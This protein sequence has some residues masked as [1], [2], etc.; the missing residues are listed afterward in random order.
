MNLHLLPL[1]GLA[2]CQAPGDTGPDAVAEPVHPI[3]ALDLDHVAASLASDASSWAAAAFLDL[4]ET[5]AETTVLDLGVWNAGAEGLYTSP[6]GELVDIGIELLAPEGAR[7]ASHRFGVAVDPDRYPPVGDTWPV[8]V[9]EDGVWVSTE[10]VPLAEPVE[11]LGAP[12]FVLSWSEAKEVLPP[13][14]EPERVAVA[15]T[16]YLCLCGVYLSAKK[17]TT[18]E[19]F[20][21]YSEVGKSAGSNYVYFPVNSGH[22]GEKGSSYQYNFDGGS[23]I[24]IAGNTRTFTDVNTSGKL[25]CADKD[26]K[27][28]AMGYW[29]TCYLAELP[30]E[31][32][33]STG[34]YRPSSS[35]YSGTTY[36]DCGASSASP[37]SALSTS[38]R[39]PTGS[40]STT[41]YIRYSST[42]V[43]GDDNYGGVF[44]D[45]SSAT[46]TSV[47]SYTA[48]STTFYMAQG[49]SCSS[50]CS[51]WMTSSGCGT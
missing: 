41:T 50:S 15:G 49:S 8:R 43:D 23:H 9:V 42:T 30:I 29:G 7:N 24:D 6:D 36:E 26:K 48:G 31:D 3:T 2:A 17:D 5:G 39:T 10:E 51:S 16:T 12:I 45:F 44:R 14:E 46:S 25:Y 11:A 35:G 4:R 21:V 38:Y 34:Q 22:Y 40:G 27:G 37:Y 28:I 32:D 19:E 33:T 18:N 47:T 1:L 20:E 13:S